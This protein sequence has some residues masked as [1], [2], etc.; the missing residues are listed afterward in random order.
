MG[1]RKR[2]RRGDKIVT[3]N[4]VEVEIVNIGFDSIEVFVSSP[5]G[6]KID[7]PMGM[8]TKALKEMRA[9]RKAGKAPIPQTTVPQQVQP[10]K[11]KPMQLRDLHQAKK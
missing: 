10:T 7:V 4:G 5:K 2:V 1:F 8:E 11:W 3:S 9:N 6:V